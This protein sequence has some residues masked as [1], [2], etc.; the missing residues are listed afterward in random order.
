MHG[1]IYVRSR[2][3]LLPS[4]LYTREQKLERERTEGERERGTHEFSNKL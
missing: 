3:Q 2:L 4:H 1:W